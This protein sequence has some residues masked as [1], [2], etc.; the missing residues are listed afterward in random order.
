M[1][2][3]WINYVLAFSLALNAAGLVA[4]SVRWCRGPAPQDREL[5]L[6]E[7]PLLRF[8]SEDL[9]LTEEQA[10]PLR[11]TVD[12]H[13]KEVLQLRTKVSDIRS[14]MMDLISQPKIDW[15]AFEASVEELNRTQSELRSRAL[16]TMM[17]VSQGLPPE[18]RRKFADY[19]QAKANL[20]DR[21]PPCGARPAQD[22]KR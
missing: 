19:L 18:A 2:W 11:K 8:L 10:A 9:N 13:K 16:K 12:R 7:K 3:R 14:R 20:R 15:Q 21:C 6:G 5:R 17:S 4:A 1:R 22:E